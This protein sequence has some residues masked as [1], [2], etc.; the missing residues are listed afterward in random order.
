MRRFRS[1]SKS[2]LEE[3]PSFRV[4]MNLLKQVSGSLSLRHGNVK[5][6]AKKN[7]KMISNYIRR[8]GRQAGLELSMDS[9]G[10]CYIPFKR[11]LIIIE[12]PE[13]QPD[14]VFFQTMVFDLE[15]ADR[16]LKVQKKLAVLQ[17]ANVR[18]GEKGSRLELDGNEVNLCFSTDISG[19]KYSD[20]VECLEDFMQTAVDVNRSLSDSI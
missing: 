12:V 10:F 3:E 11:F 18:L 20:M 2:S 13:Q 14:T 19:L 8:I 9:Y 4:N 1:W 7:R 5:P 17:Y 15:A 16:N 6:S